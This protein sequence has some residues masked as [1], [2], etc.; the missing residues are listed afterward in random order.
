[1][2][3]GKKGAK[4][5]N[6]VVKKS[7]PLESDEPQPVQPSGLAI[8]DVIKIQVYSFSGYKLMFNYCMF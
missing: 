8:S 3:K 5:R 2:F 6:E 4:L 7:K 1:M